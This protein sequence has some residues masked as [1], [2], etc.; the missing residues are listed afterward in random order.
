M[1]K[2]WTAH[3]LTSVTDKE[4]CEER[5]LAHQRWLAASKSWHLEKV[6]MAIPILIHASILSFCAGIVT[7]LWPQ[8]RILSFLILI[9][10]S[11]AVVVYFI[12]FCLSVGDEFCPFQTGSSKFCRRQ[13]RRVRELS[14]PTLSE[15]FSGL[16][17]LLRGLSLPSF[18]GPLEKDRVLAIRCVRWSLVEIADDEMTLEAARLI[19]IDD[20]FHDRDEISQILTHPVAFNHLLVHFSRCITKTMEGDSA[21]KTVT[22]AAAVCHLLLSQSSSFEHG[23]VLGTI[24]RDLLVKQASQ[25][26]AGT[27]GSQG[28]QDDWSLILVN[29]LWKHFQLRAGIPN[30]VHHFPRIL[31][32]TSQYSRDFSLTRRLSLIYLVLSL[33][34]GQLETRDRDP[35]GDKAELVTM[36]QF[37]LDCARNL[38][39]RQAISLISWFLTG[40]FDYITVEGIKATEDEK[41][42]RRWNAYTSLVL[43]HLSTYID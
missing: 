43:S 28:T 33:P 24:L 1:G 16:W 34:K 17:K 41:I 5:A 30:L 21:D 25:V 10:T 23:K 18:T 14:L 35:R 19:T 38:A 31:H 15:L 7:S 26:G 2:Q 40:G 42:R 20:S 22:F 8:H 13:W 27:Q 3:S 12:L 39:H 4:S 36:G 9:F 37:C 29:T 6:L 32:V 11:T